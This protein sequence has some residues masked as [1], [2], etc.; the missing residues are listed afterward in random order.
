MPIADPV[1]IHVEDTSSGKPI[2]VRWT[3]GQ[4]AS[5]LESL[6]PGGGGTVQQYT[7]GTCATLG[8]NSLVRAPGSG[9]QIVVCKIFLQSLTANLTTAL[10]KWGSDEIGGGVFNT[11]YGWLVLD[12]IPPDRLSGGDNQPLLLNLSGANSFRYWVMYYVV[13][14]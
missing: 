11:Q 7:S 12:F 6:L 10:L 4:F 13:A 14:V 5:L 1:L 9:Y 2:P 3:A 8:D